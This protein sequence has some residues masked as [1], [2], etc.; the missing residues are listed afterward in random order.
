MELLCASPNAVLGVKDG[1]EGSRV[2]AWL[3]LIFLGGG[4]LPRME[5][6]KEI[7]ERL[8]REDERCRN[9]DKWLTYRVM[10]EFTRI[11]IPFT[12]FENI[13]AFATVKRVR[14][15]IQNSE[16]R[17]LPTDLKVRIRRGLQEKE[18]RELM[19]VK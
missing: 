9:D 1:E 3:P 4:R 11:F 6:V 7:V 8:L 18:M 10:R 19:R 17:F 16:G 15:K 5:K 13:P 14:A 2:V 12:D